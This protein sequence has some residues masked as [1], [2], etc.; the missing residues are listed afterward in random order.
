[1]PA[2][3]RASRT[4]RLFL[5]GVTMQVKNKARFIALTAALAASQAGWADSG[6]LTVG[7]G[8]N[9]SKGNYGT[10]NSTEITSIP[11]S[12]AY[13]TGPWTM[14]LTVPY[15]RITGATDVVVGVGRAR[16]SSAG[17]PIT[18]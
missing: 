9:Y 3:L 10:T 14:K 6:T 8:Y 1:M 5:R 7:T 15:L 18:S 13:D 17:V 4:R 2:E 16:R 11:F 12:L